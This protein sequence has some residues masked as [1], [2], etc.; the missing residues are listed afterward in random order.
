MSTEKI[1]PELKVTGPA[2]SVPT[3]LPGATVPPLF[4]VIGPVVPVPLK[5]PQNLLS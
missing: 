1:D 3:E 2:L 5:F 4:T